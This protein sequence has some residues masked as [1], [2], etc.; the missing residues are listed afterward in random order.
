MAGR[1]AALLRH[2]EY[3]SD[4]GEAMALARLALTLSSKGL[5]D[6]RI[7]G[8]IEIL[9]R[10]LF[11]AAA[12]KDRAY[13]DRPIPIECGQTCDAPS[14]LGLVYQAAEI[15]PE[16]RLLQIGT[17]SG[18]GTAILAGLCTKVYTIE[19]FRTLADLAV[20][21]F[22]ALGLDNVVPAVQDG[23][24]GFARHAPF[25][26]IVVEGAVE[27][28]PRALLDQLAPQG[29]LVAAL[30][31]PREPQVLARFRR[32]DAGVVREDVGPIRRVAM[33]PGRASAL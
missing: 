28:P 17:G 4:D 25:H 8:A 16:H 1:H 27:A 2:A 32:A 15:A 11:V 5:H 3:R 22:A 10:S 31:R 26:R 13:E 23:L 14:V 18:W 19:R 29:V 24:D 9:P 7:L 21:R 30:G 6:R 20:D 33:V 12:H